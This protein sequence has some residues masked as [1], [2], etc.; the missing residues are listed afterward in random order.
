LTHAVAQH[1]AQAI[2][3]SGSEHSTELADL[4]A[5]GFDP[6]FT[7]A[8]QALFLKQAAP[9]ADVAAEQERIDR[10]QAL[11]IVCPIYWW[12][13]PALLKGWID[14]VFAQGWAY[15]ETS[16]AKVVKKLRRLRV[17]LVGIGG[18]NEGT[19]MRHG[20]ASAMRTQIDHGIFDYCGAEVRS[21]CLLLP[22]DADSAEAHLDT[23]HRI[24][25]SIFAPR[26]V[27]MERQTCA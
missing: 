21:S 25:A 27:N 23:A 26:P 18:A 17:H 10:A 19:Y 2:T 11:V 7:L 12:S 15:E 5:E 13:F 14:R 9:P 8:D 20:Y 1:I 16:D 6:R 22:A 4:A 24:G 3:A